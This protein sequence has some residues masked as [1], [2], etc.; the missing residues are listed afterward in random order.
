M[1]PLPR[2]CAGP[3][4]ASGSTRLRGR[5]CVRLL[6]RLCLKLCVISSPPPPLPVSAQV[7][8]DV[9]G[10]SRIRTTGTYGSIVQMVTAVGTITLDGA[11]IEFSDTMSHLFQD[12]APPATHHCGG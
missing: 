6:F 1:K 4:P 7:T 5:A 9:V 8:V 3:R 11:T 12:G 10:T 2:G